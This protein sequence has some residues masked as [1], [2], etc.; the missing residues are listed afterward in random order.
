[1]RNLTQNNADKLLYKRESYLI[2]GA[3]FDIYKELGFGHKELIYQRALA[4]KLKAA[5][6]SVD[7]EQRIPVSIDGER[8]GMYTPDF[9]INNCIMIELKAASLLTQQ[10]IFQFWQYMRVAPYKLGFLI[11]FGKPGGVEIVRRVYDISR[12]KSSA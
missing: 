10:D 8:I 4:I 9:V 7:R 5:G 3:C 2:R 12:K 1:M 6:L 11:N